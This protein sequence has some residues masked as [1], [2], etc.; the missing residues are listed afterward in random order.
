L[1][2]TTNRKKKVPRCSRIL[3]PL[4]TSAEYLEA[5]VV[6][7]K[8]MMLQVLEDVGIIREICKERDERVLVEWRNGK[9]KGVPTQSV[10][11]SDHVD[12]LSV[13]FSTASTII[14]QGQSSS[15]SSEESAVS[16]VNSGTTV[17]SIQERM[18]AL[19]IGQDEL[20]DTEMG[21]LNDG[22]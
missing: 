9:C 6:K 19:E 10:E 2:H 17:A 13:L 4:L 12:V 3:E 14:E 22:M 18:R 16:Q 8:S 7:Q 1:T 20:Q 15:N 21:G 11:V 5:D